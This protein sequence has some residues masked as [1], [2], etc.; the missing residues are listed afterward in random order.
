MSRIDDL[1][2]RLGELNEGAQT[3]TAKAEAEKR[4]LTT[5]ERKDLDS[6]LDSFR[7]TQEDIQRLELLGE[8]TTG[9]FQG[10]GRKTQPSQPAQLAT[11]ADEDNLDDEPKPIKVKKLTYP[12]VPAT[13][14]SELRGKAGFRSFGEFAYHVR[15]ASLRANAIIDPRLQALASATTYGNESVGADGGF[16]VPPD[17]KTA[18][19][20]KV[21]GE[22]SLLPFCDQVQTSSN[23][24]TMP[25]DET[26]PWQTTDGIQA[27]WDGE[28]FA[29]TQSKPRLEE[30]TVRLNKIRTLVPVTEELL[31]DAPGMDSYLRRKAPAKI[32]FKVSLAILQGTGVGQPLGVLNSPALVTVSKESSQVADTIVAN[33]VVKMWARLYGPCRSRAVWLINQDIEPY[34]NTLSMP[35]RDNTGNSVTGWG[36]PVY[37]P[38]G[39]LSSTPFATLFGRPVIP[40]QACETLGD[41][42]DI[43]VVDL[44]QYLALIKSGSNPRVETSMHLWFDQDLM[45]FKF[46]LR[47]GGIPWWGSPISPRDGSNT[48]SCFVTLEARA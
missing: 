1:R 45:A 16:A 43:L 6:L 15:Y 27:Y 32:A 37:T 31:E 33:N 23:V 44:S 3:I 13:P 24:F 4:D 39:G 38:A 7:E 26:T 40:T 11:A 12:R 21:T 42:G 35:G 19:M 14:A 8:Q 41:L 5:E 29:A 34:L 18:I 30:R 22:D 9:L 20:E 10:N 36:F 28:A 46:V 47:I 17:F 2:E 48:L 25:I